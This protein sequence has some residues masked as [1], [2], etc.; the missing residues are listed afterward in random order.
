MNIYSQ[1]LEVYDSNF[2]QSL[3]T[4][5]EEKEDSF[6]KGIESDLDFYSIEIPELNTLVNIKLDAA[7]S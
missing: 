4:F 5:I 3:F 7:N 2:K 1:S 6:E